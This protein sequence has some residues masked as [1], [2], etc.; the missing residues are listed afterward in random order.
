[1]KE[2]HTSDLLRLLENTSL[3]GMEEYL[4]SH[5]NPAV[6]DRPFTDY[7]RARIRA[8]KL[9]QQ[10]VFLR[11]DLPEHYAY[12]LLSME[13]RTAQRDYILRLCLGATLSVKETSRA[14]T[15]YGM[16]PLYPKAARDAILI[17][18]I[19]NGVFDPHEVNRLLEQHGE[20]PLKPCGEG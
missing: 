6:S 10:E 3:D 4:N 9:K 14:L 5:E 18:A 12:K 8:K 20:P 16:S 7:L 13:R 1:M 2:E 15:L 19:N 11:A 17:I